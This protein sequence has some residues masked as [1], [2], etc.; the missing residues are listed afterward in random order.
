MRP[1]GVVGSTVSR[2]VT[3]P[4][5]R[6]IAPAPPVEVPRGS[7][8]SA[9]VLPEAGLP[10]TGAAEAA[11]TEHGPARPSRQRAVRMALGLMV[12]GALAGYG[13]AAAQGLDRIGGVAL[14]AAVGLLLGWGSL[15]WERRRS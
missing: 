7:D 9:D 10:E 3:A 13:F 11:P 5:A 14:G 8:H 15:L 1:A 12:A 6:P 4:A 2:E